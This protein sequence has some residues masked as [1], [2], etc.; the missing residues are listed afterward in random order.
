MVAQALGAAKHRRERLMGLTAATSPAGLSTPATSRPGSKRKGA[1]K[2]MIN[3]EDG[4]ADSTA[5]SS[6]IGSE[7]VTPDPKHIRT[8]VEPKVLF[9]TPGDD[10]QGGHDVP[11]ESGSGGGVGQNPLVV[12]G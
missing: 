4:S 11:M 9:Q 2:T 3:P 1:G 7:K 8:D 5:A 12:F 10:N 6:V